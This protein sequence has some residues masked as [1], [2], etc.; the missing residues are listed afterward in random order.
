[1]IEITLKNF[2]EEQIK[3]LAIQEG[4]TEM[5]MTT[6]ESPNYAIDNP[7]SALQYL[8]TKFMNPLREAIKDFRLQEAKALAEQKRQEAEEIIKNAEEAD[9]EYIEGLIVISVE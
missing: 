3:G 9:K 6:T 1:M 2:S 4:W 8:D 7:I 5:I